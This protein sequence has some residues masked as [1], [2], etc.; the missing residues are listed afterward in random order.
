MEPRKFNSIMPYYNHKWAAEV[1]G[2]ELNEEIGPDLIDDY[3]FLELKFT[4]VNPKKH[5]NIKLREISYL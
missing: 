2:M 5:K 4:L 3:K 1:L